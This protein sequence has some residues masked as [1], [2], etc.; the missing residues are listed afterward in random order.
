MK[1]TCL[2]LLLAA[3]AACSG[4]ESPG[5]KAEYSI[6]QGIEYEY[7]NQTFSGPEIIT[8]QGYELLSLPA[9]DLPSLPI[10]KG[11]TWVMLKAEHAPYWKQI[12]QT[13]AFSIPQSLLEELVR[14]KRV[15]PQV[16]KVLLAH[17]SQSEAPNPAVKR[18]APPKSAA[19]RPL[20]LR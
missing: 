3:L 19:P 8:V 14:A 15:S 6:L 20:P 11:R 4:P 17:V 9:T 16:E 2:V 7:R 5:S 12:P 18:D 13:Q 1:H 10:S